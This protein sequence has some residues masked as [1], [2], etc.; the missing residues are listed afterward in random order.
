MTLEIKIYLCASE[1]YQNQ[2]VYVNYVNKVL[3]E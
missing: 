3:N 1:K 2:S